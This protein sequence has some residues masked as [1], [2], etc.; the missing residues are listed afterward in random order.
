M[1]ILTSAAVVAALIGSIALAQ[2]QNAPTTQTGTSPASINK[3][4]RATLP[5]GSQAQSTATGQPIRISGS[6]K[7]C[8]ETSANGPL[9][10]V[11]ASM[12]DCKKAN[13]S[14]NLRCVANPRAGTTGSK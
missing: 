9:S 4:N 11:Y 14:D 13:A 8:K 3:N 7:F 5:S 1:K 10:C 6:R 2:A 12:S